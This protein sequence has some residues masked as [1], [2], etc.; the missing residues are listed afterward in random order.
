MIQ[1]AAA[2]MRVTMKPVRKRS[3]N[4]KLPLNFFNIFF[5][6][7]LISEL[8]FFFLVNA[9]LSVEAAVLRLT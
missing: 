5:V 1:A 3:K 2:M 6:I 8:T 4:P 9:E 7:H